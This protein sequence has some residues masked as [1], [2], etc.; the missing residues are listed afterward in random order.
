MLQR[1]LEVVTTL[2]LGAAVLGWAA[3]TALASVSWSAQPIAS[4]T[5]FSSADSVE[6]E[7]VRKCDRYEIVVLNTG[8]EASKG[9]VT[10]TDTLPH[11]LTTHGGKEE[12]WRVESGR[13]ESGSGGG[14]WSCTDPEAKLEVVECTYAYPVAPGAYTPTIT[15]PVTAPSVPE[16]TSL[17]NDVTVTGG[18]GPTA[19]VR[20]ETEVSA[21]KPAFEVTNF[22]LD[23]VTA[24][25]ST[26]LQAGG[27]PSDVVAGI[28][29]PSASAPPPTGDVGHPVLPIEE[30]KSIVVELPVGFYGDPLAVERCSLSDVGDTQDVEVDPGAQ[31][32]E[33]VCERK[34]SMAGAFE[35]DKDGAM[36]QS[37]VDF[38]ELSAGLYDVSPEAGYPAEFGLSYFEH[39]ATIYASV[40]RGGE[41]YRLRVEEPGLNEIAGLV[42]VQM[43]FFGDP[44]KH[45]SAEGPDTAFLTN[46]ADCAGGPLTAR[47]E[48]DSWQHPERWVSR[49]TTVY[50]QIEDCNLLTFDPSF[51]MAPSPSSEEGTSQADEPSAYSVDLKVPQKTLFEEAATPDLKGASVTLPEG[52][53]VSP[54]AADGLEGCPEHGEHGIDIPN[55]EGLHPDEAGEG[56]EIGPDG[57]AH[58]VAGHCPKASALGTVEIITPLL[59][60]PLT[61]HVYLAQPKCGGASQP[62]CTE[63][64]ATNGELYG[65]YVEA[66]GSGIVVKL[67][68]SVSADPTT[69]RLTA[70]FTENPQFPFSE[71]K[72]HFHGGPRAP[73]ANPQSCGSFATTSTLTSWAGQEVS[74]ASPSFGIDWTGSGG[75]C[76]GSLPFA[77]LF[78]AGTSDVTAGAFSPFVLSFSRND[79]EQNLGG[80]SVRLP[81]GLLGRVAGVPLCSEAQANAGACGPE[82]QIGTASV[83]AGPGE[84]PLYVSGGRVYLTTGYRG[85]PFGLS[86]VVPAVAGPYN[87][88]NVV[89]RAAIQI[90]PNTSQVTV[91]SDSLPQSKDGVPFRLREVRTEIDRAGFTLNPT[92]CEEEKVV[93][94]IAGVPLKAGEAAASADVS[95]PFAVTGCKELPF[96]PSFSV[97]TQAKTSKADGASLTVKVTQKPGEANIHKV[98]LTLPKMLPARLTTLQKACTEVQFN[99]NPAGCP[100]GSLIGTATV[101]TP[102]LS[103]ALTGPAYLVSHGHAA[104]PD[105]EFVLQGE[106]VQIVLD[107]KTDI[108]SGI[109]YSRFETVPDAPVSSFETVLPEGPHSA[110]TTEQPGKT[111][112]CT[113]SLIIP[114]VM[115]GQNGAQITQSTPVKAQG[116]STRLAISSHKI[117]KRTLTLTVYVPAAGK[118]DV[119]ARGLT[120]GHK[121]AQSRGTLTFKLHQTRTGVLTTEVKVIFTPVGGKPGKRQVNTLRLQFRG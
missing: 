90:D 101:H 49:E 2:A 50:P 8:E 98:D 40:A 23:T 113:Q 93:G 24:D 11:G 53:S 83:L 95:S 33:E 41:G 71:L 77:P 74:D 62:A 7:S 35:L 105:V 88:G 42:D 34:E 14:K 66:E 29:F 111:N 67:P 104:F 76:P 120:S 32:L 100:E 97:F 28:E 102:I 107:G 22:S 103:T 46:P 99:A 51:E 89:V 118:V 87:L 59:E 65:L 10:V 68:G 61:G 30:V 70:R 20:E 25:G 119:R 86:I 84:H 92:S 114:T 96:K 63:A 26:S 64:S 12:G 73:L 115:V 21:N 117:N 37:G 18:G 60:K 31:E 81:E 39:N 121:T 1:R 19:S 109:T 56:E 3:S 27:H 80:L 36:L 106:G 75:A 15:I 78:S 72:M 44:V 79:R 54:S 4:P 91:T 16:G 110:L 38:P 9:S 43:A 6:C 58:L 116:C 69:G 45:N 13:V 52:V 55:N 85:A 82:S 47:V 108:K 5:H 94:E 17:E 48:A 112:L 57:L